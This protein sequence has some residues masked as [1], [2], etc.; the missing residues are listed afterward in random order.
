[1]EVLVPKKV[2]KWVRPGFNY[3]T[4]IVLLNYH[5]TETGTIILILLIRK[6]RHRG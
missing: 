1:M 6:S 4:C 5:S 2:F 3:L